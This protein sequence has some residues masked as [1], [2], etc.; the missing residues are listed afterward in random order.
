MG[1]GGAFSLLQLR[2]K[3]GQEKVSR[4]KGK[5]EGQAVFGQRTLLSQYTLPQEVGPDEN[6]NKQPQGGLEKLMED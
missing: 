3:R 4:D 5:G 2:R 1:R 6:M